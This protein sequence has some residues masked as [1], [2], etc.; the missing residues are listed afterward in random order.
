[1]A[2]SPIKGKND[3]YVYNKYRESLLEGPASCY[4]FRVF[5]YFSMISSTVL[6][7]LLAT[8]LPLDRRGRIGGERPPPLK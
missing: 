2:Y 5:S 1:M 7:L 4:L 3:P 6:A 8:H